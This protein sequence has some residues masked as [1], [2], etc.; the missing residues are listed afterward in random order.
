MYDSF[1][2]GGRMRVLEMERLIGVRESDR[3]WLNVCSRVAKWQQ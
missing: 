1:K 2:L 3:V